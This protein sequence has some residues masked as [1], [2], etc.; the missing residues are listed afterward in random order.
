MV[1]DEKSACRRDRDLDA[2][3]DLAAIVDPAQ[4][5][6][7]FDGRSRRRAS[8]A[9]VIDC[10]EA[11]ITVA[12]T[13]G[14]PGPVAEKAHYLATVVDPGSECA[15]GVGADGLRMGNRDKATPIK[16]EA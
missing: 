6:P 13:M 1:G 3:N 8:K 16:Q 4:D 7:A 2:S 9:G 5:G 10:A 14:H 15:A 12:E 11:A